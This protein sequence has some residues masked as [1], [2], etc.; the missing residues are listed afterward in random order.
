MPIDQ[1]LTALI[2]ALPVFWGLL[3]IFV[4]GMLT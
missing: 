2:V 4:R 1:D 3:V